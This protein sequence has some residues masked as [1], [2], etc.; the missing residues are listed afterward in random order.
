VTGCFVGNFAQNGP[1]PYFATVNASLFLRKSCSKFRANL[2]NFQTNLPKVTNQH[3]AKI[4]PIWS[5][6]TA[7][8]KGAMNT[9]T[10]MKPKEGEREVGLNWKESERADHRERGRKGLLYWSHTRNISHSV[11]VG[12]ESKTPL[13][14]SLSLPLSLSL[15]ISVFMKKG[16]GAPR[17]RHLTPVRVLTR[18]K[19]ISSCMFFIYIFSFP[20][21]FMHGYIQLEMDS[22]TPSALLSR[23]RPRTHTRVDWF[24]FLNRRRRRRRRRRRKTGDSL[25]SFLP[26]AKKVG[27]GWGG[28]TRLVLRVKMRHKRE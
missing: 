28:D 7:L 23:A 18:R 17:R 11:A 21:C 5:P 20:G 12:G 22:I 4:R 2:Y 24:C 19:E 26:W 9:N 16:E 1:K 13:S 10:K 14:L 3:I 6:W 15:A 25:N 8:K 27:G